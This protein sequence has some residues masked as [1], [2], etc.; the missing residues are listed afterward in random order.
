MIVAPGI[1]DEILEVY[2]DCCDYDDNAKIDLLAIQENRKKI[3]ILVD[4]IYEQ[5]IE[6][7]TGEKPKN[8]L[9][10][11]SKINNFLRCNESEYSNFLKALR[12]VLYDY[13]VL[14]D[15]RYIDHSKNMERLLNGSLNNLCRQLCSQSCYDDI[16]S[17]K[18]LN[19]ILD[20]LL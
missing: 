13:G 18:V 8:H 1:I 10:A 17:A 6:N 3:K 4:S 16:S 20:S 19:K 14:V 9:D 11:R 2:L 5:S 15:K 12:N 7:I